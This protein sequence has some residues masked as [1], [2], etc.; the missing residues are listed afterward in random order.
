M[1]KDAGCSIIIFVWIA[2]S[3]LYSILTGTM[4]WMWFIIDSVL[5]YFVINWMLNPSDD[6]D[7]EGGIAA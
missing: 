5:L 4:T 2:G 6:D 1:F 7:G 3:M